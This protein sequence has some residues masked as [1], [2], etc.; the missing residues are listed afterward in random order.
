MKI[1]FLTFECIS[2]KL[3]FIARLKY[4]K[5]L[6]QGLSIVSIFEFTFLPDHFYR[7]EKNSF[8]LCKCYYSISCQDPGNFLQQPEDKVPQQLL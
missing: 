6:N 1:E 7:F 4:R 8:H 5:P 2:T 3:S